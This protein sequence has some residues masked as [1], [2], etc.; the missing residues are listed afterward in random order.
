MSVSHGNVG[1]PPQPQCFSNDY[2]EWD[3]QSEPW[4]RKQLP[5]E[6]FPSLTIFLLFNLWSGMGKVVP[7]RT[8]S[9]LHPPLLPKYL[10]TCT[11]TD[12]GSTKQHAYMYMMRCVSLWF[13][14]IFFPRCIYVPCSHC[15]FPNSNAVPI[16][17]PT[18]HISNTCILCH[19]KAQT[20]AVIW[21]FMSLKP[22]SHWRPNGFTTLVIVLWSSKRAHVGLNWGSSGGVCD[23]ITTQHRD[24]QRV[25]G[26]AAASETS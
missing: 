22:Q 9:S 21:D 1:I 10:C 6:T 15:T 16:N 17:I 7:A 4:Q 14:T 3:L 11:Y 19:T 20:S 12:Y 23:V 8:S 26:A 25:S 18:E 5:I 24:L 13:L 2:H